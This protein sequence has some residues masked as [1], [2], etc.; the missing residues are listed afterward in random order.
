MWIF[1]GILYVILNRTKRNEES[2]TK[3][4][5]AYSNISF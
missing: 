4:C 5:N 2:P 1:E 3:R